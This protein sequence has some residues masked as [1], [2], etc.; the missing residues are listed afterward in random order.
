MRRLLSICLLALPFAAL[1]GDV[2][3]YGAAVPAGDTVGIAAALAD[4]AAH[5]G[6]SQ[7]YAG[8][9]TE[10]C[11]NK[12]CWLMLEDNGVAARVMMRDHAFAVP[13][14]ASGAAVVYGELK[15]VEMDAATAQH[16]AEDGGRSEPVARQEYRIVADGVEIAAAPPASP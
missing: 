13:K 16:L 3:T 8:R 5:A 9:I 4:P 14:D 6:K 10:V 15:Q 1:A 7:R 11:Q 2:Q 12:G